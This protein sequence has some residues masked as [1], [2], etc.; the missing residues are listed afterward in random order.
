MIPEIEQFP[1]ENLDERAQQQHS[2]NFNISAPWFVAAAVFY[3]LTPFPRREP[4][5][6]IVQ[7]LIFTI[8]VQAAVVIIKS[9]LMF[10]GRHGP[11]LGSW[12]E[13]AALIWSLFFAIGFGQLSASI[14]NR[15]SVHRVLRD[16]D[17]RF[18][19]SVVPC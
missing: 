17:D 1:L 19:S 12:S 16:L 2:R 13:D 4:F 14:S 3:S 10:V 8:V 15:D 5:E 7:A 18:Q 6:R 9:I 11:V